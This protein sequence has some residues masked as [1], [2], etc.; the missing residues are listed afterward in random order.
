MAARFVAVGAHLLLHRV[1]DRPRRVDRLDLDAVDADPPLA[2]R[3]VEHAP[4]LAVDLVA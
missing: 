3:L 4:Q 2:G 1:L